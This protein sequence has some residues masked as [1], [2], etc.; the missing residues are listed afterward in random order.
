LINDE[1]VNIWKEAIEV[2]STHSPGIYA[3]KITESTKPSVKMAGVPTEIQ[4][5]HLGNASLECYRYVNQLGEV[6]LFRE[7]KQEDLNIYG[8][9]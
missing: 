1:S 2:Q 4:T 6:I 5:Q 7:G 3:Q 9:M 8:Q